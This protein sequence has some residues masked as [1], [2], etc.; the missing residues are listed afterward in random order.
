MKLK[1]LLVNIT[2]YVDLQAAI[3]H[4]VIKAGRLLLGGG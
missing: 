4:Q 3:T 2:S 1:C